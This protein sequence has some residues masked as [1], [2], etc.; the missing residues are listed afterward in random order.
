[1]PETIGMHAVVAAGAAVLGAVANDKIQ[2]PFTTGNSYVDTAIDVGI[3]VLIAVGGSKLDH[4][5]VGPAV[6][7]FGLGWAIN[8]VLNLVGL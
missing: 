7:G 3:G 2:I 5:L 8:P 6:V 4:G 1:M